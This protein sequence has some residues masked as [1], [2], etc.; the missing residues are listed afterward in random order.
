MKLYKLK[1]LEGKGLFHVLDMITRERVHLSTCDHM[2]DVNEGSWDFT[3]SPNKIYIDMAQ[4]LRKIVDATRFTC[5]LKKINNPL[6]WAHYAGGF[7]GVALEYEIDPSIYDLRKIE[8]EGVPKISS[9]EIDSVI[10]GHKKP[11]D[12]GI[13][14]Q[15]APCWIYENEWRLYG[16]NEGPYIEGLKP[17]TVIFGVRGNEH[18]DVLREIVKKFDVKRAYMNPMEDMDFEVIYVEGV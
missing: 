9:A 15:K 10:K 5:F 1:S 7:S 13:L 2:N 8:Y 3:G 11:Q 17:I 16:E 6:M 12:I 14:K 18:D 4:K